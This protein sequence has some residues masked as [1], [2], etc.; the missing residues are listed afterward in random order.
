[1]QAAR[2]RVFALVAWTAGPRYEKRQ[3]ERAGICPFRDFS[4]IMV[5][6]SRG[7]RNSSWNKI[8]RDRMGGLLSAI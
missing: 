4:L 1:M 7:V 5:R 6:C 2:Y 8:R 3:I